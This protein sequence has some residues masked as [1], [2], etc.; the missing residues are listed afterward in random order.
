[1]NGSDLGK[2]GMV[3]GVKEFSTKLK[4]NLLVNAEEF[5]GGQARSLLAWTLQNILPGIAEAITRGNRKV[6]CVERQAGAAVRNQVSE[7][8]RVRSLPLR[9][10]IICRLS[11]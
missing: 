10:Y 1:M 2:D 5:A 4:T 6:V 7:D 9:A 8:T 11:V 3:E